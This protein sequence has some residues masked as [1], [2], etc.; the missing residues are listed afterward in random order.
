MKMLLNSVIFES[1]TYENGKKMYCL[2]SIWRHYRLWETIPVQETLKIWSW[3]EFFFLFVS[4]MRHPTGR[5]KRSVF[6]LPTTQRRRWGQL[7]LKLNPQLQI[8]RTPVFVASNSSQG[9][10]WSFSSPQHSENNSWAYQKCWET[11]EHRFN[12]DACKS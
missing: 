8:T 11:R 1:L 12:V 6:E 7:V 4:V 5:S 9:P 10:R 2:R 3:I